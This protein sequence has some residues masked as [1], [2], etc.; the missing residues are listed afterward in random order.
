[1]PGFKASKDLLPP[2][3]A[4]DFRLKPVL[5]YYSKNPSVLK[6]HVKSTLPVFYKWKNKT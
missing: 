3:G 2:I 5:I 1:M 6:N 4:D